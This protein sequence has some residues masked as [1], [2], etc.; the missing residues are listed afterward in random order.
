[1]T[2]IHSPAIRYVA[3]QVDRTRERERERERER[4]RDGRSIKGALYHN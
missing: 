3:G 2:V 1:M 4:K